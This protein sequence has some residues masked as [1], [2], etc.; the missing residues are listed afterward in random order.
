MITV[1]I[2]VP[3]HNRA[4]LLRRMLAT[5]PRDPRFHIELILVN[6]LSTDDSPAIVQAF[7]QE[8][9]NDD[10]MHIVS[11]DCTSPGAANAR[12]HG[13][14]MAHG[15]WIYFFDSDDTLSPDFLDRLYPVIANH[16]NA[17]LIGMNVSQVFQNGKVIPRRIFYTLAPADQIITSQY[18]TPTFVIRHSFYQNVGGWNTQLSI[19]DDWYFCLH[20]L[21]HHPQVAWIG[22]STFHHIY[23]HP[24][25]I[26]G[27]GF[28]HA[29]AAIIH[30][31]EC[32][33]TL[34]S[35]H[36]SHSADTRQ[37]RDALTALASRCAIFAGH[38]LRE[39]AFSSADNILRLHTQYLAEAEQIDRSK[40]KES[41]KIHSPL[42]SLRSVYRRLLL[43]ALYRLTAYGLRGT[44]LIA[45]T[46][47]C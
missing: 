16:P 1:S 42:R 41:S 27:T 29:S 13:A 45:R 31:T 39:H 17:E 5:V 46:L 2:I 40:S 22:D 3:Y 8:H 33:H 18:E 26:T 30:A 11:T 47:L 7:A 14:E 36:L 24:N 35:A 6:N 20:L 25:S 12:N 32:A 43:R 21:L 9:Q 23:I 19:W 37:L 15:D 38:F 34:L 28:S 4:Q 44:W 10:L